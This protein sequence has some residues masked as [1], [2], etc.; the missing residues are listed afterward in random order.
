MPTPRK[1][2]STHALHGT[3]PSA[4]RTPDVSSVP[5]GRPGIPKDISELGLR[6]PF[7]NLC[8][9]LQERRTLTNGDVELIRLFCIIQAR[10]IRNARLLNAEGELVTYYRLD[11]NGQS[12]PQVKVNLRLKVCS[13]A[14]RQMAAILNQLGMTP[15]AKDRAKPVFG[16]VSDTPQPGT[17]GY[18]LLHQG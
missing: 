2:F 9:L 8:A 11:S 1:D 18:F 15:T 6:R 17:V 4:D 7:K 10:H 3:K 16:A 13:D 14:E 12:V 5:A